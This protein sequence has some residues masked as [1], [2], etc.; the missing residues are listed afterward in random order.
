M[1]FPD[2]PHVGWVVDLCDLFLDNRSGAKKNIVHWICVVFSLCHFVLLL[3]ELVVYVGVNPAPSPLLT[4][5]LSQKD[6]PPPLVVFLRIAPKGDR[7]CPV[8]SFS[9]PDADTFGALLNFWLG[10]WRPQSAS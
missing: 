2:S 7:M 6:P 9:D 3:G 4:S 1:H 10:R 8:W 5:C